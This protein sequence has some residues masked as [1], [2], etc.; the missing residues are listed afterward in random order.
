M[1][2][3]TKTRPAG[4]RERRGDDYIVGPNRETFQS[5]LGE[6]Q[7]QIKAK[8]A[9]ANEARK[10]ADE[11]LQSRGSDE[12]QALRRELSKVLD[13]RK[14][15]FQ[16]DDKLKEEAAVFEQ[17]A[18]RKLAE[19]KAL[20]PAKG[21]RNIKE[22]DARIEELENEVGSGRLTIVQENSNLKTVAQLKKLRTQYAN[23]EKLQNEVTELHKQADAVRAKFDRKAV[24]ALNE[25]RTK[26]QAQVDTFSRARDERRTAVGRARDERKALQKE[27]DELKAKADARRAQ[28]AEE[29]KTF[30]AKL[31]ETRRAREVEARTARAAAEDRK[32]V[33]AARAKVVAAGEPAFAHQL[34]VADS[35]ITYFRAQTSSKRLQLDISAVEGLSLLN[36]TIP[37]KVED[38]AQLPAKIEEKAEFYKQ[39]SERVTRERVER[40]QKDLDAALAKSDEPRDFAA[41][42]AKE[43]EERAARREKS[44]KEKPERSAKSGE[45]A[46]DKKKAKEVKPTAEPEPA[47]E[48]AAEAPATSEHAEEQ[49]SVDTSA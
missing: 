17:S 13:E 12:E 9:A 10:R 41:E 44:D 2:A 34:G 47:S 33:D 40:A 16:V 11:L 24:A 28:F 23:A 37:S 1:S 30:R 3:A 39:N 31:A 42:V 38:L 8:I 22:L 26:L 20:R 4:G 29:Q 46:S 48:P 19:I 15:L 35:L 36:I 49:Q 43:E 6:L 32:R 7:T 14:R 27:I 25:Q 18:K 5:E 21:P 45:K